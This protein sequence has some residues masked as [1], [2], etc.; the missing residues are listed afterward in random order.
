M[1]SVRRRIEADRAFADMC[2]VDRDKI[3]L[4]GHSLGSIGT[5]FMLS[6]YGDFFSAAVPI[7]CGCDEPIVHERIAEVPI[8]AF[9]G[10][11]DEL[12]I[13]YKGG[14]ERIYYFVLA[15]GGDIEFTVM[16]GRNHA[17]TTTEP[18]TR[19]LFEWMLEQ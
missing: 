10:D 2:S 4:T 14:M 12:E 6:K 1:N 18:Y 3:I 17:N 7:S 15:A 13:K 5:W 11:A 16:Y 9:C 8:R 19:E